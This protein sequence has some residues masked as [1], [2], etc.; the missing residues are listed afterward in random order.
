MEGAHRAPYP[1]GHEPC[2]ETRADAGGHRLH[3]FVRR[4]VE[5]HLE[6]VWQSIGRLLADSSPEQVR[7]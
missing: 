4:L 6:T 1:A 7:P 5:V 2:P 3:T